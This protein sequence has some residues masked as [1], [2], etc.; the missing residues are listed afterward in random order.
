MSWLSHELRLL[1]RSH[2]S[3][4]AL[5]LLFLLSGLAVWSGLKEI[6]HQHDTIARLAPLQE[7]D[8]AAVAKTY[9]NAANAGYPA[10]YTFY[11]TWD[12]PSDAAFLSIGIRDS[13][14][15]VL[16]VR[17]LGLQAQLYEGEI[18][19]PE[20][21]LP[22]RFDF[23]FV[24]IY[25]TPLFIIALMHD[26]ISGEQQ[27]GRLR[28]LVSLPEGRL[29]WLRRTSLRFV[30]VLMC[31]VIPVLLGATITSTNLS[32]LSIIMAVISSYVA[33]WFGLTLLITTQGWR[34]VT[35]ATAL[36]SVWVLLTLVLPSLA[37][38]ALLRAVPVHQGVDLMLAQR[39]AV[40]GAW[41]V[42]REETMQRFFVHHPEWSG[43]AP[44]PQDFHWKWYFAFHQLGDESVAPLANAYRAGLLE[45]Q[46]WTNRLG[47]L[48]PGVGAQAILHRVADTDLLAQ[49]SYQDQIEAFH[50]QIREFYYAYLFED[51][52]FGA[53]DFAKQPVFQPS[54]H[55][56]AP[57]EHT[58]FM[59]ILSWMVFLIGV[60]RLKTVRL[61]S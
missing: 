21:A 50:R 23:A 33:F 42:P 4:I 43:T 34:S 25:L 51:R 29:V 20:L 44:L 31:L 41:E 46:A 12:T 3:I 2:L 35:N 5:I 54:A 39:Q 32:S 22:G 45:R 52:P 28:L 57:P 61:D 60:W 30:L 8:L 49:L 1:Q 13:A 59:L 38:V 37:N 7:Q 55:N 14:P 53:A 58:F 16:R 26:M 40:H 24:L 19:N 47:W 15:Y 11:S 10:Y 18:F 56:I 48:L 17:A 6:K 9:S 27:S 36:M